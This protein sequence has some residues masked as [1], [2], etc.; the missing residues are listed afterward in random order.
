M[1]D[2]EFPTP[3]RFIFVI[4]RTLGAV[5]LGL[6]VVVIPFIGSGRPKGWVVGSQIR[7]LVPAASRGD[8]VASEPTAGD[9]C[10]LR[11]YLD[12]GIAV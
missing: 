9:D 11:R 2:L 3:D 6:A 8:I 4:T 12:E 10:V 5:T 7:H 1:A